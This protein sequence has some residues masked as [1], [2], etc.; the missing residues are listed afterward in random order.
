MADNKH[1]H[2]CECEECMHE[3]D[4]IVMLED[5]EGNEVAFH[6]I[7]T[8]DRDGKEYACLQEVDDEDAIVEIFELVEV[9]ENGEAFYNFLIV[10]DETYEVLYDQLISEMHQMNGEHH[11]DCDHDCDCDCDDHDCD[12]EDCHCHCHD[13]K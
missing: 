4:D 3:D 6:H 1:N 12:S 2:E 9:E 11:C 5:E 10:D 13:D 7:A 8:L